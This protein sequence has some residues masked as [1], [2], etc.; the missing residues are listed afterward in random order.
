MRREP[1]CS[2]LLPSAKSLKLGVS[3]V[4]S[5][6]TLLLHC[7][8]SYFMTLATWLILPVAICLSQ[9]LSHACLSTSSHPSETANGSLNHIW[10]T[11]R[12]Q[13]YLD[14]CGNS[15]ANTC[16]RAPNLTVRGAF[17]R[18]RPNGSS[19]VVPLVTLNDFVRIARLSRRRRAAPRCA[20]S[21]VDCGIDAHSGF[22]G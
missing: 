2:S 22:D 19:W 12:S 21:T 17:I 18:S 13:F 7:S 8:P 16:N 14:N 4:W 10:R 1:L 15:G 11:R 6:Q 9:R 5:G 3:V 20:L